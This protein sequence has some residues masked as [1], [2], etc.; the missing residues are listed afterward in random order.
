MAVEEIYWNTSTHEYWEVF[1]RKKHICSNRVT[2][3]KK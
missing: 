3:N 2:N 1:T